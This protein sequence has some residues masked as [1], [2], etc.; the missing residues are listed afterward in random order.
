MFIIIDK[1]GTVME[2]KILSGKSSHKKGNSTI[3]LVIT[4]AN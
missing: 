3:R 4:S 2:K 1:L